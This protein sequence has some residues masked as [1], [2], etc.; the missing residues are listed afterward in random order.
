LAGIDGILKYGASLFGRKVMKRRKHRSEPLQFTW[1]FHGINRVRV[2]SNVIPRGC[3]DILEGPKVWVF[4]RKQYL[5]DL[6]MRMELSRKVQ[7]RPAAA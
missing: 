2:E 5:K 4:I 1:D 7:P 6:G 3:S